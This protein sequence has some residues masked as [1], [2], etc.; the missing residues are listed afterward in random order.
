MRIGPYELRNRWILAPMAG[1]SEMPFRSIA[2]RLGAALCPTEL[3]SAEGTDAAVTLLTSGKVDA[4][5]GLRQAL[6]GLTDRMSGYRMVDGRFMAV[7]QSI[8]VPKGRDAGLAFL[9]EVVEDAKRS[10]LVAKAIERT[11]ARGVSVAP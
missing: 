8:G 9:R 1:I 7:Q 5:A 3:V 2:F 10:G 4:L 6:I 11:G